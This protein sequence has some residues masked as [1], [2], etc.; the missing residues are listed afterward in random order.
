MGKPEKGAEQLE[1]I[2]TEI[3]PD[4]LIPARKGWDADIRN[5]YV[6]K[7]NISLFF[8][9]LY[10]GMFGGKVSNPHKGSHETTEEGVVRNFH[11]DI[12]LRDRRR[13]LYT[14]VKG[15][16][17]K[18][19]RP[20]CSTTQVENYAYQML[21]TGDHVRTKTPGF[22][23]AFFRY[24]DRN[25]AVKDLL[26]GKKGLVHLAEMARILSAETSS[27]LVV[28][29]N[30][31]FWMLLQTKGKYYHQESN[32]GPDLVKYCN[33]PAAYMSGLRRGEVD[34]DLDRLRS[35]NMDPEQIRHQLGID[36][37]VLTP[38]K[39]P[40]IPLTCLGFPINPF[41]IVEYRNPDDASWFKTFQENHEKILRDY[42]ALEDLYLKKK[43][44]QVDP[45]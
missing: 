41:S 31:L 28:P 1:L 23:Y 17:G 21:R 12:T 13:V 32:K 34:Y 38:R 9:Y 8:E 44:Q 19:S 29:S 5:D 10:A 14:E 42:L 15:I 36:K 2:A 27:L 30:F 35:F 45:F 16:S 26:K 43:V 37:L 18:N 4:F 33:I 20:M 6:L 39:S 40:E 11:P 7:K 24:G 22:N 3:N 25:L